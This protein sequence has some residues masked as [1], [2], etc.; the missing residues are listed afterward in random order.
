MPRLLQRVRLLSRLQV[1][2][3]DGLT[4][5]TL[6]LEILTEV[7]KI[8]ELPDLLRVRQIC[9]SLHRATTA[10]A[11]WI[12][13]FVLEGDIVTGLTATCLKAIQVDPKF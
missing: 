7:L 13:G 5:T 12:L 10:K 8:L 2:R 11:I 3:D 1:E 6:P 9:R 4:I